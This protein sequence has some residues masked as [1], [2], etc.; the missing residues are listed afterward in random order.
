MPGALPLILIAEFLLLFLLF[1]VG[2]LIFNAGG[3]VPGSGEGDV[4]TTP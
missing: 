1:W 4:I 3:T 2:Y